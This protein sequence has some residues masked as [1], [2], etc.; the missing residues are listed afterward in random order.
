VLGHRE[1]LSFTCEKPSL[2]FHQH[3]GVF[4]TDLDTAFAVDAFVRLDHFRFVILHLEH[5]LR[6]VVYTFFT[7]NTFF[8]VND[9][10]AH[11]CISF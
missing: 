11:S 6:T 10:V 1:G 9:R 7:A 4:F 8:F 5:I 3:D 2:V